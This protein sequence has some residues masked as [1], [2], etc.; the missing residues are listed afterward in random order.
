MPNI[1]SESLYQRGIL[2]AVP[3]LYVAIVFNPRSIPIDVEP[4]GTRFSSTCTLT[5]KLTYQRPRESSLKLPASNSYFD[6]P[7]ESQKPMSIPLN[8][9]WPFLYLAAPFLK[10]TQPSEY[11]GDFRLLTRQL[12]RC[13]LN[14]FRRVANS[15]HVSCT[16]VEP[17]VMPSHLTKPAVSFCRSNPDSHTFG[18]LQ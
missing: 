7:Y 3:S 12:S 5:A 13:F 14:C 17:T 18:R 9:S 10:G 2:K 16:V 4:S 11:F 1:S 15:S 6:S 8:R